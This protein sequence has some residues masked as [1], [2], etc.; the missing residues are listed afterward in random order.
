M[1]RFAYGAGFASRRVAGA[2]KP[3]RSFIP[4]ASR[5]LSISKL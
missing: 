2:L 4:F 5:S 3:R 1:M